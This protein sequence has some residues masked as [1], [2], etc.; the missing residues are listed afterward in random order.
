MNRRSAQWVLLFG[1]FFVLASTTAWPQA[2]VVL[3]FSGMEPYRGEWF[4]ARVVASK[5]GAEVTRLSVPEIPAGEFELA[6]DLLEIGKGYRVDFYVD[7]NENHRYD[8]PP[9]DHAWRLV[10][11]PIV[12]NTTIPVPPSEEFVEIDWPPLIDGTIDAGDYRHTLTD[13][14][15][16]IEVVWQNDPTYLYVGLVSPGTGWVAIGFAPEGKMKGANIVIAAVTAGRLTIQDHFGIAPTAH[17][18]DAVSEIIQAAG[19]EGDGRT[20]I[21]FVIP[22]ES[23]DPED[24]SLKPGEP[25]K[26]ILAYHA[27]SDAFT[28]HHTARTTTTI[29]LD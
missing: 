21:E 16:G 7:Q 17:R 29:S 24:K 2:R 22:L 15:T 25:V 5:T 9:T 19:S 18:E 4:E 12:Q 23:D 20:V 1:L 8:P 28:A 6:F 13:P 10:L 27:L 26:V 3:L 11:A 14:T